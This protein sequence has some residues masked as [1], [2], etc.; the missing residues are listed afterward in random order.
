MASFIKKIMPHRNPPDMSLGL[1][2]LRKLFAEF[3]HPNR[4]AS[5][6]HLE[7]PIHS[8]HSVLTKL[9]LLAHLKNFKWIECQ[10]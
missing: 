7:F 3:R 4:K 9:F 8:G 10:K 1:N 2:H 5:G 6:G